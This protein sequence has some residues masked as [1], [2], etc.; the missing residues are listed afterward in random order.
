MLHIED[1]LLEV[2]RDGTAV[3]V[4]S[5]TSKTSH[6]LKKEKSWEQSRM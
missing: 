2:D 1:S 6:L 3:V 5:N 4:V